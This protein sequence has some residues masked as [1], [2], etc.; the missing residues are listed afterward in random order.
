MQKIKT[1]TIAAC[2]LLAMCACSSESGNTTTPEPNPTPDTEK[3]PININT[4]VTSRATDNAFEVND[5]IGLFVVNYNADGTA[6]ALQATGNHVNNMKYTYNGSWVPATQT[7]WKDNTTHADFYMYYPYTSSISSVEAMPF[8]VS[9]DQSTKKTDTALG[10]YEASDLLFA[11]S[12]GIKASA[13]P[14]DLTFK[15]IMS[16]LTIRLVKGEDFEGEMPTTAEVYI[17]NT[18]PTATVDLQAGVATRYVKG[19]RQTITANQED[20]YIYSA[21]IVPQLWKTACRWSR[22]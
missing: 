19:T 18:V 20:D 7:Y 13:S 10:G 1:M 14:I 8:S 17:H 5:N 6:A 22:S 3:I 11:T 2:T 15:H 21:I 4:T 12:K 16:K 9:A